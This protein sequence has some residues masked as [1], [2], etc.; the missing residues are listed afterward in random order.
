MKALQKSKFLANN[1]ATGIVNSRNC[2]SNVE[3]RI[4]LY[5]ENI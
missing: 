2:K 4:E 5:K 3:K 1:S